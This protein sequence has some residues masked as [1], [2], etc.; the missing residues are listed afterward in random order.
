[1]KQSRENSALDQLERRICEL[2]D[3]RERLMGKLAEMRVCLYERRA[4]NANLRMLI[5]LISK[6]TETLERRNSRKR[7]KALR[8]WMPRR[9]H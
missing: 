2:E 1:M 5:Q 7:R 4:Y 9:I 6:K 3:G 8:A